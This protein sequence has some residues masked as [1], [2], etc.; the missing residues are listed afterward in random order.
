MKT[1]RRKRRRG[2]RI[3]E[4]ED[5][6]EEKAE[7]E[8]EGTSEHNLKD[9]EQPYTQVWSTREIKSVAE[10]A[11]GREVQEA[12]RKREREKIRDGQKR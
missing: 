2:K 9:D 12:E 5:K 6:E 11:N 7:E 4:E 3:R 1:M 10:T 8:E